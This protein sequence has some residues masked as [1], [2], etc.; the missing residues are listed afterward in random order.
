MTALIGWVPM[1]LFYTGDNRFHTHPLLAGTRIGYY[2]GISRWW[3]RKQRK[4]KKRTL[5]PSKRKSVTFEKRITVL[6]KERQSK[7]RG[8]VKD[9]KSERYLD[10]ERTIVIDKK[11]YETK[12]IRGL[13][14]LNENQRGT[15][16]SSSF[17][18]WQ[19]FIKNPSTL[20]EKTGKVLFFPGQLCFIGQPYNR[21]QHVVKAF[22]LYVLCSCFFYY[23]WYMSFPFPRRNLPL[24]CASLY[25][26]RFARVWRGCTQP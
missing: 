3:E 7:E 20:P 5:A 14:W 23:F 21:P 26:L 6:R 2:M 17:I 11:S 13:E 10:D 15:S 9:K 22:L 24:R 18:R 19:S 25:R 1:R 12:K 4:K 8:K 16:G